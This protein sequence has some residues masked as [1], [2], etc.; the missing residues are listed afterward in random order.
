VYQ[1]GVMTDLDPTAGNGS[2]SFA[3]GINDSGQIVGQFVVNGTYH[4]FVYQLGAPAFVDIGALLPSGGDSTAQGINSFGQVVGGGGGLGHAF[5]YQNGNVLDLNSL[6]P[7]NSGWTLTNASG[8]N[9]SGQIVGTGIHNGRQEAFLLSP[10]STA[11][12]AVPAPPAVILAGVGFG[13]LTGYRRWK[14]RRP[15]SVAA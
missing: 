9:D 4:A 3:Y 5:L 11:P 8:V 13:C 12:A 7:A 10:T 1:N 14:S 15:V 2:A 6:L